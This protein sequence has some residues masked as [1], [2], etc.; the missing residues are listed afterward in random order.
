[1]IFFLFSIIEYNKEYQK[2]FPALVH[3]AKIA[4]Q[5]YL[6]GLG[7]I[8]QS[9][10]L[11][12][13]SIPS[14][15]NT[16]Q[17]ID[18]TNTLVFHYNPENNELIRM[19]SKR[20]NIDNDGED[21]N[22]V[23]ISVR[24][25]FPSMLNPTMPA[26]TFDDGTTMKPQVSKIT[27]T[28]TSSTTT[29]DKDDEERLIPSQTIQKI[30]VHY[31]HNPLLLSSLSITENSN[32]RNHDF[33]DL[34]FNEVE[35][36]DADEDDYYYYPASSSLS[37]VSTYV[38]SISKDQ[39]WTAFGNDPANNTED[40]GARILYVQAMDDSGFWGPVTATS[41]NVLLLEQEEEG[42]EQE[43]SRGDSVEATLVPPIIPS[44]SPGMTAT[45]TPTR[46]RISS[47]SSSA[48]TTP[49]SQEVRTAVLDKRTGV[50]HNR[51]NENK[52]VII[53]NSNIDTFDNGTSSSLVDCAYYFPMLVFPS[54]R[55]FFVHSLC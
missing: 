34:N 40:N 37:S 12:S 13:S 4:H 26:I 25:E 35:E 39:F 21:I 53:E 31:K 23:S 29:N 30:R 27:Q 32:D 18:D 2:H 55:F 16:D 41:L 28:T 5:P 54:H 3:L 1:M 50:E 9:V 24:I 19:E 43:Q 44:T 51:G 20:N 14:K 46:G 48:V 47:P 45:S 7:P 15:I 11:S 8:L 6:L 22:E 17:Q 52:N 33:W 36:D 10:S 49:T 38:S 42:Q